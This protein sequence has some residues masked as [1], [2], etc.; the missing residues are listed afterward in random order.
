MKVMVFEGTPEEILA[1]L[2]HLKDSMAPS[3]PV[4]T[5]SVT[6]PTDGDAAAPTGSNYVSLRV[7]RKVLTRRRLKPL[8]LVVLKEIYGAHPKPVL[9]TELHKKTGYTAAQ[10]AGLMGAIGRRVSH[11]E[12]YMDGDLFFIQDWN[13]KAGCWAY[14][15]P[16][17]VREALKLEKIV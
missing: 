15:L 1:A 4:V 13:E 6:V 3:P 9:A 10:F 2:P 11:T 7:A 8:Q 5:P 16:D 14:G 12:G 17:T